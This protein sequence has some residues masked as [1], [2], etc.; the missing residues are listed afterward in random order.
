[1]A[2]AGEIGAH[3]LARAGEVARR[4]EGLARHRDRRQRT[5]K[6]QPHQQLRVLAIGL[7]PIAG[8]TRRLRGRDH[9]DA[10]RV[11]RGTRAL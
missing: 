2:Q 9:V 11:C 10:N 1:V 3:L 7:D 5:G 6:Q 4:L 8:S